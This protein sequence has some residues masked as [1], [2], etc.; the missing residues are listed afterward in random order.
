[1]VWYIVD[2]IKL[3]RNPSNYINVVFVF[4]FLVEMLMKRTAIAYVL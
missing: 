3:E 4:F 2:I 1:M